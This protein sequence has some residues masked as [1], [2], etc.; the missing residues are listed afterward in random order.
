MEKFE[1]SFS[2]H[3]EGFKSLNSAAIDASSIIYM[4]KAGFLH[5][6][7]V[8]IQ[9]HSPITVLDQTGFDLLQITSHDMKP[10]Q[11]LSAD[12][13][14]V[15]L[16]QNLSIPVI[17]DDKWVLIKARAMGFPFYNSLM[18]LNFLLYKRLVTLEFFDKYL[19]ELITIAR[20]SQ[21]VIQYGSTV[22]NEILTRIYC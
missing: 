5:S 4:Q 16:A 22:T 3:L 21:T 13:Q 6:A 18:I 7:I 2:D 10:Y 1:D 9:L 11:Q 14:L 17:S 8:H 19:H 15:N 12:Q 20:Y